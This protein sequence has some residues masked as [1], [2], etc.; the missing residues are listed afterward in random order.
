[1]GP[2]GRPERRRSF[3]VARSEMADGG[4]RRGGRGG[5]RSH[6]LS[7]HGMTWP[8]EDETD[9][10]LALDGSDGLVDLVLGEAHRVAAA[11]DDRDQ[12]GSGEVEVRV[13]G[14]VQGEAESELEGDGVPLEAGPDDAGVDAVGGHAA[15]REI[16]VRREGVAVEDGAVD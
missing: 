16:A 8:V 15:E 4:G 7:L 3:A 5:G 1:M 2:L 6:G 12:D 11:R 13:L 9:V 10:E 14:E